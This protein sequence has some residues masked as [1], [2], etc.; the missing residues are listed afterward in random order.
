MGKRRNR[1]GVER[2]GVS[3]KRIEVLFRK[4][5]RAG[6]EHPLIRVLR[7]PDVETLDHIQLAVENSLLAD[8][9]QV[10][11]RLCER[12]EL[13]LELSDFLAVRIAATLELPYEGRH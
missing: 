5:D 9:A 8:D 3:H 7:K 10:D 12:S 4:L 1:S 13:L 11:A 2:D 6:P